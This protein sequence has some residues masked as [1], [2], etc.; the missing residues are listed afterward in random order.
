[1]AKQEEQLTQSQANKKYFGKIIKQLWL[2]LM[3]HQYLVMQHL[4]LLD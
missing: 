4:I 2:E 1:M 3:I